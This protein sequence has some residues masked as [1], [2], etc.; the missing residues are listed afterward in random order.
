MSDL[1]VFT[2]D[3]GDDVPVGALVGCPAD[4]GI[5]DWPGRDD[6]FGCMDDCPDCK[7]AGVV[8]K[9]GY[10]AYESLDEYR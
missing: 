10:R 6:G 8:E 3:S 4:V 5:A 2:R 9:I 1:H 7:G